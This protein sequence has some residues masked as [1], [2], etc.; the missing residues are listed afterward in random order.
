MP[1]KTVKKEDKTATSKRA[2]LNDMSEKRFPFTKQNYILML[3]GIAI[4]ILGYAL[5]VGGKSPNPNE[6]F[7]DQVYSW[8]R[9]TLAPIV[10]IIGF[11]VEVYAIMKKP[12]ENKILSGQNSETK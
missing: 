12:K 8:R 2:A 11:I 9:I 1:A 4:L 10:V 7:P 6:F 3:A 5:M